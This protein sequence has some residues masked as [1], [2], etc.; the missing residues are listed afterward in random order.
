MMDVAATSAQLTLALRMRALEY[1]LLHLFASGD[2]GGTVHTCV[3][4]ELV[5]AAL[6][7]H[8]RPD[9]D[10]VFATHR[11]HGFFL[12]YGGPAD[13][14]LAE[15]TG[16]QGACCGGRG[17]TQHLHH[18]HFF[19]NGIQA[20]G[21]LHAV[22][23][24]WAL[25]LRHEQGV[26]IAQIG[27]GTLGEG[28]LYEAFTMAALLQV[29]VLFVLEH[30]GFAQS[31]DTTETTPGI[32]AQRAA[33]FGIPVGT[34]TGDDVSDL[35]AWLGEAVHCTR[36]GEGPRLQIVRTRRLLAHSKGD[37]DRAADVI[38]A[39][40]DADPLARLMASDPAWKA[41]Y[42]VEQTE[43]D[44]L[45]QEVLARPRLPVDL[46]TALPPRTPVRSSALLPTVSQ[47]VVDGLNQGLHALMA[48]N[49][50]VVAVGED[51]KDPYGGAFKV[52]RGLSSRF[53]ERVFST[54]IAEAGIVGISNGLALAGHR[55]VA[56]LMFGDFVTLATDQLVN[57]A[58]KMYAMYAVPC[59][60][61]CRVVSGGG[62]GYGPTH[63]QSL[64]RLFCGIPG[65]RVVALSLRHDPET[66]LRQAVEDDAPVVFVEHKS[67]Y[68][69]MT[70]VQPPLGYRFREVAGDYPNLWFEPEE[71]RPVATVVTYGGTA[72][73]VEEVLQQLLMEQE[74]FVDFI[75]ASQL[76]P[77]EVEPILTSAARTGHLLVA[78]DSV[79]DYGFGAAVIAAVAQAKPVRS[80]AV[81]AR[82]VPLP[83]AVHLEQ[84]ALPSAADIRAALLHL[85][86]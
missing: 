14:L 4:Q 30:N 49:E 26:A 18:G 70:S 58:A 64:E 47:R 61:T 33:G 39:Q 72:V 83:A 13:G 21:S 68:G 7:P 37:D 41:R 84:A 79:P 9:V 54:P 36:S 24:A 76:W 29:P 85:L 45:T 66:L 67:L 71:G 48:S 32:L 3:G 11:G 43:L 27:D 69:R 20:S 5:A 80:R 78:E 59:P 53:P 65:L 75:I 38:S 82:P 22:G 46:G 31:T 34:S 55:P 35:T 8:L 63:S 16:R 57:A 25:K 73:L 23:Y 86:G 52:T 2:V 50:R 19:S 28:A 17:G 6:S 56:E 60:I 42:Q 74:L 12:A 77:L 15:L 51:I 1:K 40:W 10:A 81:G 44:T 62:R